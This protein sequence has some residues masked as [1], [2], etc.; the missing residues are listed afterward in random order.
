MKWLLYTLLCLVGFFPLQAQVQVQFKL[1]QKTADSVYLAG[2]INGWNPAQ[3]QYMFSPAGELHLT[4]EPGRILQ[5]KFTRGG[6]GRAE[7]TTTG[8]DVS[9]RV[10]RADRDTTVFVSIEAWKDQFNSASLQKKHTASTRVSVLDTAFSMP[11]LG[12][13]RAIRIYLPPD[14]NSSSKRYPVLYMQ[15][16]QNC[17]DEFTSGYGEWHA[18]ETLDRFYDSCGRS[19]I[20][21]AVDH[22]G[23]HRITEYNPYDHA[24]YGKGEGKQ[25]TDFIVHRLKRFIDRSFRTLPQKHNTAI[26]GSSM[27]GLI[28]MYAVLAYPKTF[29]F[30]GIFSPS[31]WTAPEIVEYSKRRLSKLRRSHL[32][33]YAGGLES[34][35]MLKDM[36][37]VSGVVAANKKA[38]TKIVVDDTATH[39]EAAWSKWFPVFV[40]WMMQ[41][42]D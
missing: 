42:Q 1:L 11:Q 9:N 7:C 5:Y 16:G 30:A 15:D 29:G 20:I 18:D 17:F 31:F 28:S 34:K 12:R 36:N 26:M 3:E 19:I 41:Q 38:T 14:Y 13:T 27:G 32:F 25:Y 6:W 35:N 39:N 2:N 33:F 8:T 4:I 10:L 21:V 23:E 37:A 24:E 40:N 22:G